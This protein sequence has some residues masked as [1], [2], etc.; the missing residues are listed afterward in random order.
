MKKS[1]SLFVALII[2]ISS[3]FAQDKSDFVGTWKT[4]DTYIQLFDNRKA[5]VQFDDGSI[6]W[7]TWLNWELGLSYLSISLEDEDQS[8][9]FE[10]LSMHDNS[11]TVRDDDGVHTLNKI[12]DSSKSTQDSEAEAAAAG[13]LILGA[14][15]ALFYLMSGDDTSSD[16][17]ACGVCNGT[18]YAASARCPS[19]C[20]CPACY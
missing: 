18:K 20:P 4:D 16:N 11:M 17:G 10:I 6:S 2:A 14:A 5:K 8:S 9:Y 7:G 15:A 13:L 1:I 3:L 12:V 19:G